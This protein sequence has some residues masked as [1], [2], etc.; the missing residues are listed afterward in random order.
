MLDVEIKVMPWVIIKGVERKGER[1]KRK[2]PYALLQAYPLYL[3]F[4]S[5]SLSLLSRKSH[6]KIYTRR[7]TCTTS[8]QFTCHVNWH[9]KIFCFTFFSLFPVVFFAPSPRHIARDN[10][11]HDVPQLPA[12]VLHFYG[13]LTPLNCPGN[14]RKNFNDLDHVTLK[15]SR[16][17]LFLGSITDC[18][19]I[20]EQE[21]SKLVWLLIPLVKRSRSNRVFFCRLSEERL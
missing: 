12:T 20:R 15:N 11:E 16:T 18:I 4:S 3:R 8:S 10:V 5:S 9:V 21:T 14:L 13:F 6:R 2:H 1:T 17:L 7:H 19:I